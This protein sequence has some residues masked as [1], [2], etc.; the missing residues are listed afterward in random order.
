MINFTF[1][2]WWTTIHPLAL[3]IGGMAVYSIFIFSFYKFLSKKELFSL[4]LDKYNT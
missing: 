2:E 4:H 3:F 1:V